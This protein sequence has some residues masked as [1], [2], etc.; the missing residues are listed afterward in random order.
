MISRKYALAFVGDCFDLTIQPFVKVNFVVADVPQPRKK[1][2]FAYCK[3]QSVNF[4]KLVLPHNDTDKS[5]VYFLQF[6]E[7]L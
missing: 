7:I 2:L 5:G 3:L 1:S 6:Q 4:Q